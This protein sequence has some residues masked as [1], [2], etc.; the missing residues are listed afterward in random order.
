MFLMSN[1]VVVKRCREM[2]IGMMKTDIV[3]I[4]SV[5]LIVGICFLCLS[6][7]A[8]ELR[9]WKGR[10]GETVKA[11]FVKV[12]DGNVHL[13][14]EN[15]KVVQAKESNLCD[16]DRQY[17]FEKSYVPRDVEVTYGV[18]RTGYLREDG[19]S[20]VAMYGDQITFK[21]LN[22]QP[23][24][25]TKPGGDSRWKYLSH[26]VVQG[27]MKPLQPGVEE[28][29]VSEGNFVLLL[30][31]VENDSALPVSVPPPLLIDQRNRKYLPLDNYRVEPYLPEGVHKTESE[32]VQ[33]GFMKKFCTV[34]EVPPQA[35]VTALEA[36][37]V[38]AQA[39]LVREFKVA[40]KRLN[41][42][43]MS[44]EAKT[45]D[46][47]GK[48]EEKKSPKPDFKVFIKCTRL[49]QGGGKTPGYYYDAR[50]ERSL[51][52]GV[53]L[54][55]TSK[56]AETLTVKAYFIGQ[57]LTGKDV[58]VDQKEASVELAPGR[59]ERVAVQ[60]NEITQRRRYYYYNSE[61]IYTSAKLEG[62]MIQIWSG[63]H[64]MKS[65]SSLNQWKKY[66]KSADI[67]K[68]MGELLSDMEFRRRQ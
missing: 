23:D 57:M 16:E 46:P 37:P 68:T 65:Y 61:Q 20:P 45:A 52:Y 7:S 8:E 59:I 9:V 42:N 3:K 47:A 51:A 29:L 49:A 18:G 32:I 62:V 30:F 41:F 66:Q 26:K 14:L 36:F 33:P 27:R 25:S 63:D 43:A 28:D 58:V 55:T 2:K 60:S 22:R 21:V 24:G 44:A 12:E 67:P 6:S 17:V 56:E 34:Y 39:F 64:L 38:K 11:S 19:K 1:A 4:P 13:K 53:E 15:G 35:E 5:L 50:R 10:K 48:A 40:G 54:R 31:S